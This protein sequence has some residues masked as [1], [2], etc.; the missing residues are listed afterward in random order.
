MI[1][2]IDPKVDYALKHLLGRQATRPILINVLNS[3]LHPAPGLQIRDLELLDPFNPKEALDDKLSIL[4]IKARDQAGRQFNVEMQ[5]LGF[6]YYEK[7]ILY[8][9]KL[10][11]QQLHEG[12]DYLK[13][14]PTISISF[15][16]H[17]LFPQVP[18][19]H[20]RFRLLEHA[21]QVPFSEDLEFHILELPKFTKPAADL[22]SELDIL[23]YFLRYVEKMDTEALPTA[24][25][26][27]PLVLRAFEE[28]KMLT[29]TD[30]ER[31][32]YEARRKAQLDYNTGLK[33]ARMEGR[34]EGRAEGKIERI[35][36]CERLLKRPLTP[37][38]QLV[39]RSLE[40]LIKLA[41][42]LQTQIFKE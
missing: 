22:A 29:Q 7:R 2:G 15:L 4:D 28:L 35:H 5:M 31:E 17:A 24:L 40:D 10:H 18:D 33:V 36:L 27:Q 9:C 16:D 1:L 25:Q 20:L 6:R 12:E 13:L 42:D 34:A 38:E 26:K 41:D 19:Y 21:H 32:R 8:A 3:V 37:T 14:M 39:S 23:L 30:I 11:Q